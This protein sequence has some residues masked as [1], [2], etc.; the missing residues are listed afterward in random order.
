[1]SAGVFY[2]G[3]YK[4]VALGFPFESIKGE[5]ARDE[6]MKQILKKLNSNKK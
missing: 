2:N 6:F 3:E 4:V 5:A 1:V